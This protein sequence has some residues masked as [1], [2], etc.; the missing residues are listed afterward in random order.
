MHLIDEQGRLRVYELDGQLLPIYGEVIA[1]AAEQAHGRKEAEARAEEEARR[2]EEAEARAAEEARGR[3][4]AEARAAEEARQR[5][6]LER[7][8]AELRAALSRRANGSKEGG[9]PGQETNE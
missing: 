7:E 1:Q 3:G 8:V 5:A 2:R 4:E 9:T 6:A